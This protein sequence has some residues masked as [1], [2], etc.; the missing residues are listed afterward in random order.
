M[1][2]Y[3]LNFTELNGNILSVLKSKE[4][5]FDDSFDVNV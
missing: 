5:I 4:Y 1:I 2:V 3:R